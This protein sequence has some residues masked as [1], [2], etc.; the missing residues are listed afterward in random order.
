MNVTKANFAEAATEIE[1][2]LPSALFVAIDEEMTGITLPDQAELMDDVPATRYAKLRNVAT[3][4]SIIQFGVCLFHAAE[5]DNSYVA[6]PYNFYLFPDGGAVSLEVAGIKFLRTHNM[7]FN[8]WIYEG[9][10]YYSRSNAVRLRGMLFP[11]AAAEKTGE[12]KA[13]IVLSKK[14]DIDATSE[15]LEGLEAWLADEA[16]KDETEYEVMTTNPYLRKYL[17]DVVGERYPD[18]IP[19][20]RKSPT[21]PPRSAAF[22]VQRLDEEQKAKRVEAMRAKAEQDYAEK[23]GF[24]RVFNALAEAKKPLVG[25]NCMCD[26]LFMLSHF[27]GALP[28][29]YSRFKQAITG[30]FDLV[31]DTKLLAT[32]KPFKFVPKE[33]E[34]DRTEP[35]QSR[36]GST[37]LGEVFKVFAEEAASAREDDTPTVE[38]SFAQ[39]FERYAG[40]DKAAAHEAAYDAYMTGYAFAHMVAQG[41]LTDK[42]IAKFGN[43]TPMFRSLFDFNLAGE[44]SYV[45]DSFYVHVRGHKGRSTGDLKAAIQDMMAPGGEPPPSAEIDVRWINDDS[46]FIVLP[47]RKAGNLETALAKT[48]SVEGLTF[49]PGEAWFDART[50][51][52]LGKADGGGDGGAGAAAEEPPRKRPK[53]S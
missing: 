11:E 28:E 16:K 44:D 21:G 9:V 26:L 7:D 24:L 13:P 37:A 22:V 31:Y 49:T 32:R 29:C 35:R 40:D 25:H 6:R 4:Y 41:A 43:R 33:A 38:V 3:R 18:L 14:I 50:A 46:S 30:L 2:L 39:G 42:C 52:A 12:R 10:P 53:A 17:Y 19:Q 45:Y 48:R 23:V 20:T 47:R 27:Y 15:A 1:E 5:G 8:K 51:A 36:F 34:A